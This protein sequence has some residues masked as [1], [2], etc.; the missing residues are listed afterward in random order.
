MLYIAFFVLKAAQTTLIEDFLLA[1]VDDD[2]NLARLMELDARLAEI[3]NFHI[4]SVRCASHTLELGVKDTVGTTKKREASDP[5]IKYVQTI[6]KAIDV[7]RNLRTTKM[8]I[9]I[10]CDELLMPVSFIEIRWSSAHKMVSHVLIFMKFFYSENSCMQLE[11]INLIIL[12]CSFSRQLQ[13]LIKLKSFIEKLAE[14]DSSFLLEWDLILE[15]ATALGPVAAT[16]KAL[17]RENIILSEVY[18][19]WLLLIQKLKQLDSAYSKLLLKAIENRFKNIFG[20]QCA[21]MLA[22]VWLDPRY[23][24]SLSTHQKKI[25]KEHLVDLYNRACMTSKEKDGENPTT[26]QTIHANEDTIILETLLQD[27]ELKTAA[28]ATPATAFVDLLEEFDAV[29]REPLTCNPLMYWKDKRSKYPDMYMLAKI[30]FAVPGT[31]AA[32]ERNFSSLNKILTQFRSRLSDETLE[33][34]LF[35]RCNRSLFGSNAFDD[36]PHE[37]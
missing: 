24:V 30:L 16:T 19:E 36:I 9:E 29:K 10:E 28:Q 18:G 20:S 11:A 7:V 32:I 2:E 14:N 4:S 25:A 13:S 1:N 17:Q 37:N 21:P 33:R 6:R 34:T 23:R 3:G 15:I 35:L 31:Q 26:D 5:C 22:C 8:K 27:F 12:I